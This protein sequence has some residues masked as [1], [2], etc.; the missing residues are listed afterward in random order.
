MKLFLV[1]SI[2]AMISAGIYGTVDLAR[3]IKQGTLIQYE[4]ENI[5]QVNLFT[6]SK[7]NLG[8]L[9][10]SLKV[11]AGRVEKIETTKDP[12]F[13]IEYFSRGEAMYLPNEEKLALLDSA[14]ERSDS[15]AATQAAIVTQAQIDSERVL[16][17]P[18]EER[19]F[20]P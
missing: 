20:S 8:Q 7:R 9:T 2:V 12:D 17:K 15:S 1:T 3:D 4:K 6:A 13:K 16:A 18:E 19:K 5:Q 10:N 11:Q 14:N